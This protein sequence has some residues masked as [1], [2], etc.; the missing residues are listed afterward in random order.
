MVNYICTVNS[1]HVSFWVH[2]YSFIVV[3]LFLC[4]K[5]S[6][7]WLNFPTSLISSTCVDLIHADVLSRFPNQHVNVSYRYVE[8]RSFKRFAEACLEDTIVIYMDHLLIQVWIFLLH[9]IFRLFLVTL[10]SSCSFMALIMNV[11]NNNVL[12]YWPHCFKCH[13]MLSEDGI[14]W[15]RKT[16][17]SRKH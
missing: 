4:R 14:Y 11:M 8:E 2:E 17:S 9:G 15:C 3:V 6:V 5:V 7:T 13:K 1:I 16:I 10:A 12:F